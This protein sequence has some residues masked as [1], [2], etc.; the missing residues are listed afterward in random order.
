M[1]LLIT[2]MAMTL[3]VSLLLKLLLVSLDINV[4]NKMLGAFT[5]TTI[6]I[7]KH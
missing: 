4:R 6:S 3:V 2:S 5:D 7:T 1:Q